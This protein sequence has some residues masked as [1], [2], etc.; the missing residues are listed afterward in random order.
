MEWVGRNI[1]HHIDARGL[2]IRAGKIKDQSQDDAEHDGHD[3]HVDQHKFA[4]F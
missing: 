4:A 3:A 2:Q 1:L